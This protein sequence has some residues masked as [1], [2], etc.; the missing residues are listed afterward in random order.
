MK[1]L[2]LLLPGLAMALACHSIPSAFAET[3]AEIPPKPIVA[4]RIATVDMQQLF[5]DYHRTDDV[6]KQLNLERTRIQKEVNDRQTRLRELENNLSNLRKQIDDPS[7]SESKRQAIFKDWQMQQ[8]EGLALT[9]DL[10]EFS[11][12]KKRA[13]DEMMVQR[14]KAIL[15]EIRKL[16]E[17]QAK[18]EN[19]D[20]VFD[21]SGLST[22]Q[23]PFLLFTKDATDITASLLKDLNKDAPKESPSTEAAAGDALKPDESR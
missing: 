8:Q 7:I 13:L 16:V 15:N 18:G 5:K 21:R 10:K 14:M 22:S 19:Y 11:D 2:R 1:I 23:V 12:R 6:Q 20:Y 4:L 9:R 17:E 3:P